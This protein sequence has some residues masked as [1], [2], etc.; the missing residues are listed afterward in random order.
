MRLL[1]AEFPIKAT[2]N[3]DI[4]WRNRRHADRILKILEEN[5]GEFPQ[6]FQGDRK[7]DRPGMSPEVPYESRNSQT[8]GYGLGLSI[9]AATVES[10]KG[11]IL[12]ETRDEKSLRITVVF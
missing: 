11:K 1:L 5:A 2:R 4:R 12:A 10:H 9:A 7:D 8:G 3:A 6:K